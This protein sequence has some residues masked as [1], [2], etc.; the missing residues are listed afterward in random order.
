MN[1]KKMDK[2]TDFLVYGYVR[3]IQ[4]DQIIPLSIINICIIFYTSILRII[5][6]ENNRSG[7]PPTIIIAELDENKNHKCN[8]KPLTKLPMTGIKYK[9]HEYCGICY[10]KDFPVPQYILQDDKNDLDKKTKLYDIIFTT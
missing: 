1:K 8:I 5:Y 2:S 7:I 9:A 10:V 3:C 4:T 6:I